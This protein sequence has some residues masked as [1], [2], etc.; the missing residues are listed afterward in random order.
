MLNA[1]G[2]CLL[3]LFVVLAQAVAGRSITQVEDQL[4]C[5]P[6]VVDY[7]GYAVLGGLVAG[8]LVTGVWIWS[9]RREGRLA[10]QQRAAPRTEVTPPRDDPR[11]YDDGD[12]QTNNNNAAAAGGGGGL[13]RRAELDFASPP[14][15]PPPPTDHRSGA[16]SS[17]PPPL[18]PPR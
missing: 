1:R 2:L 17:L 13:D 4:V 3:V 16:L 7:E 12:T 11:D 8:A 5:I 15:P 9:V 10:A 6:A 18:P 14:P